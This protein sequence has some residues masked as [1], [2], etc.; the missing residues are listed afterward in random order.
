MNTKA[1]KAILT[2][3]ADAEAAGSLETYHAELL[4]AMA[5][6][7]PCDVLVFNEFELGPRPTRLGTSAVTCTT[8]PPLEPA[9]AVSPALITAFVRHLAAHP[10]IR[11]H[12]AGDSTA[13]RLSD[14]TGMRSFRRVALYGEFFRPAAIGHQLTLGLDGPPDRLV[15]IW[16]NRTRPDFSDDELLLAELLRPHLHAAELAARRAAAR[17]ALTAREREVL[18]LVAA[19][20]SNAAVAEVLVVSPA[21][22]KKHLENIYGKLN[23]G[24]RTA[25]AH[26]AR[27]GTAGRLLSVRTGPGALSV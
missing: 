18:D 24:S 26:R 16:L 5:A 6:A 4:T 27:A 13:H 10:L 3:T 2:L 11:L 20:A 19:G 9:D 22:V 8:S 12:A 21:T 25:A 15:G 7:F 23:V 17:A 14:V 1:V